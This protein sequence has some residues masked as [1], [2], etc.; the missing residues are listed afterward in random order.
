MV[1]SDPG[2]S[3]SGSP[4][5]SMTPR[6]ALE[7]EMQELTSIDP[8]SAGFVQQRP[9]SSNT[10]NGMAAY[11]NP[12]F[13]SAPGASTAEGAGVGLRPASVG[14]V[15]RVPQHNNLMVS[16]PRGAGNARPG[17]SGSSRASREDYLTTQLGLNLLKSKL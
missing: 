13:D 16:S 11:R 9:H 6:E 10:I 8:A 7:Q 15:P 3:G 14:G 12:Y 2:G 5:R 4:A 17:S 1:V